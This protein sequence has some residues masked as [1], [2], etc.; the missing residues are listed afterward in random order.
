MDSIEV[1]EGKIPIE[2]YQNI[3]VVCGLSSKTEEASRI[4]LNNSLYSVMLKDKD[5]VIGMGRGIGDGGCFCQVVDICVV[6]SYQGKGI[7]KLIM[8]YITNY[9]SAVLPKSCYVSLIA[10]GN[11]SFL[12]EKYG[13]KP[14]FPESKG[15]YLSKGYL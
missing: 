6:P 8:E 10:D 13:F 2:T 9:I 15:M 4:G 7:G 5:I 11:A 14:T 3:R 1:E 12:Y